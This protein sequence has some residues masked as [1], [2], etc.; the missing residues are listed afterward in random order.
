VD[1]DEEQ[2]VGWVNEKA[3]NVKQDNRIT[4]VLNTVSRLG[5]DV[6]LVV[7]HLAMC[8]MG[9]MSGSPSATA[10]ST[11]SSPTHPGSR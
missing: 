3:T 11:S 4:L 7:T 1:P 8:G 5:Y 2:N 9:P 6:S 10:R